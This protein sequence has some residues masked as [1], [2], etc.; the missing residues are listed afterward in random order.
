MPSAR[1]IG[2]IELSD[3]AVQSLA[4]SD[5]QSS[6]AAATRSR[7]AAATGA[8]GAPPVFAPL[9]AKEMS[10]GESEFRRVLVPSHRYTPLKESWEDI[11]TPI[12]EMLGLQVRPLCSAAAGGW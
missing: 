1:D 3:R 7:A 5:L 9:S 10:N 12:V 11:Y 4:P 6:V 2:K 8:G